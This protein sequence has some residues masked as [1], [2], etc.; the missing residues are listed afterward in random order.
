M[1][2]AF[3]RLVAELP[4]LAGVSIAGFMAYNGTSAWI[5]CWF[6]IFAFANIITGRDS[7]DK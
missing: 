7:K 3:F 6:L 4:C 5:W 2:I 1:G